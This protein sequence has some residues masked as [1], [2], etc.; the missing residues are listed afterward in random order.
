VND[1]Q[2]TRF[3]PWRHEPGT[4]SSGSSGGLEKARDC[5]KKCLETGVEYNLN[6]VFEP[7]NEYELAQWRL[8]QLGS[9]TDATSQRVGP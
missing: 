8:T 7:K 9:T 5:F 6:T 3:R 2:Y 4:S 1:V